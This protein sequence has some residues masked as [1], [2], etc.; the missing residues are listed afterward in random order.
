[1]EEKNVNTDDGDELEL[2][3]CVRRDEWRRLLCHFLSSKTK[4]GIGKI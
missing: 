4:I 1:M 3:V 2:C